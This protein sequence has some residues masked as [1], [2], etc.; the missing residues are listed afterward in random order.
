MKTDDLISMLATG[1]QPVE[2]DVLQRRYITALGWGALGSVLMM[3]I[4]LGVRRDI[5]AAS[6]LPMFWVKMA[7][8][9]ALLAGALLAAQRLSRPGVRL[10][11]AR[12]WLAAPVL[13]MGLLSAVVLLGAEPA[14]RGPLIYGI[15]WTVCPFYIAT[16]SAPVFIAVMWAMKGLAPARPV[17]AGAAAGLVAGTVGALA[18]ALYCPEMA[19][20]FLGIWYLGGMLIPSA[21]GAILGPWLLRW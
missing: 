11:G 4:W 12:L 21:V 3:A 10:G 6:L 5:A 13:A 1:V 8:P 16:L 9:G 17:P 19:A 20:P 18:Y 15:S 2:A 14:G 7:Y